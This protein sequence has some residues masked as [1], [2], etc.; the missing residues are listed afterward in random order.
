MPISESSLKLFLLNDLELFRDLIIEMGWRSILSGLKT[1]I[2]NHFAKENF[3]DQNKTESPIR[4]TRETLSFSESDSGAFFVFV[5]SGDLP[6]GVILRISFGNMHIRVRFR[7]VNPF[8]CHS[9]KYT[10]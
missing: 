6:F 5:F 2:T 1:I 9:L 7:V 8:C 10:F 3:P 4:E